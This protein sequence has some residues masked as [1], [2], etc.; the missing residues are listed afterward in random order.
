MVLKFLKKGFYQESR[1]LNGHGRTLIPENHRQGGGPSLRL[2]LASCG[3]GRDRSLLPRRLPGAHACA[4]PPL[5]LS[6]PSLYFKYRVCGFPKRPWNTLKIFT[7]VSFIK[8][9]WLENTVQLSTLLTLCWNLGPTYYLLRELSN[10]QSGLLT[11]LHPEIHEHKDGFPSGKPPNSSR[12]W[13]KSYVIPFWYPENEVLEELLPRV[14]WKCRPTG[15]KARLDLEEG[16]G[17]IAPSPALAEW[18]E[19]G[20]GTAPAWGFTRGR[21]GPSLPFPFLLSFV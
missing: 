7:E 17:Q 16:T 5:L 13:K 14:A 4:C 19:A 15:D 9:Y 8:Y 1:E 20:G 3:Q 12:S 11:L 10:T 6:V 21:V 2:S 18:R